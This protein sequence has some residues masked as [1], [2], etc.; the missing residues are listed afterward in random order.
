M[1]S[2]HEHKRHFFLR[3]TGKFSVWALAPISLF[4]GEGGHTLSLVSLHHVF[5]YI[6]F[7]NHQEIPLSLTRASS[8]SNAWSMECL[9][10]D[11][12]PW[13][14][15]CL[16]GFTFLT[17]PSLPLQ[18]CPVSAPF[19]A[20]LWLQQVVQ[21]GE[22]MG[23]DHRLDHA[24]VIISYDFFFPSQ[25][26]VIPRFIRFTCFCFFSFACTC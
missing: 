3:K 10:R 7:S 6:L 2:S 26:W 21:C 23:S 11:P 13:Y 5:L 19:I 9:R 1:E 12:H 16:I 14:G 17:A 15:Y 22:L 18:C 8:C 20:L 4:L 24:N 25:L